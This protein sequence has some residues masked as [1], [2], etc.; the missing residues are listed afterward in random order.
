MRKAKEKA[1]VRSVLCRNLLSMVPTFFLTGED[2][3]NLKKIKLLW[4]N[5]K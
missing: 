5:Y 4:E 3:P 2:D 1:D